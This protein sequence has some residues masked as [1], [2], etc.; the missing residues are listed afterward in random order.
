[1]NHPTRL[2][3]AVALIA[4]PALAFSESTPNVEPVVEPEGDQRQTP[5]APGEA[6]I[7]TPVRPEGMEEGT[8]PETPM[9]RQGATAEGVGASTTNAHEAP[10]AEADRN[11][12]MRAHQID[13]A[14]LA[15]AQMAKTQSA[16]ASVKTL[17]ATM[18]TDHASN[19]SKVEAL[20]KINGV[21]LK[22][23]PDAQHAAALATLEATPAADFDRAYLANQVSGHRA[24]IALYEQASE[25]SGDA[26]VKALADRRLPTLRNHLTASD[27]AHAALSSASR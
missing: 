25:D 19:R 10:L 2:I 22:P 17:A 7:G 24:A 4:A 12:L 21:T 20:A 26:E 14:Q 23:Q 5:S 1:M 15:A 8:V 11:F 9:D 6:V 3:L 13:I 27:R 16:D 18:S